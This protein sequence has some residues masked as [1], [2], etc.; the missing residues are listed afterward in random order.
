V[1][2][3]K[4]KEWGVSAKRGRKAG[5]H[6]LSGGRQKKEMILSPPM[7]KD[8]EQRAN[9]KEEKRRLIKGRD[10]KHLNVNKEKFGDF[11]KEKHARGRD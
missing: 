10:A 4:K 5:N 6:P 9:W 3:K 1:K 2:F 8:V 7:E 11:L